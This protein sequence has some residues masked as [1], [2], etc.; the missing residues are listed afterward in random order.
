[1]RLL[2]FLLIAKANVTCTVI[3]EKDLIISRLSFMFYFMCWSLLWL[4]DKSYIEKRTANYVKHNYLLKAKT[5]FCKCVLILLFNNNEYCYKVKNGF[6]IYCPIIS[7]K[8]AI[9]YFIFTILLL[10]HYNFRN[11]KLLERFLQNETESLANEWP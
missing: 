9:T 6:N 11:K 5:S 2:L 7:N 10:L 8:T 1:M 4:W 3:V